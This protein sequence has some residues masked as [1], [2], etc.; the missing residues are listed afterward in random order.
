MDIQ[1]NQSL[2]D[3]WF[4]NPFHMEDL[5]VFD[6]AMLQAIITHQRFGV[7]LQ[8]LARSCRHTPETIVQQIVRRL[9]PVQREHLWSEL[10]HECTLQEGEQAQQTL[11]DALFWELIYWKMPERYEELTEGED[12]HPDLFPSLMPRLRGQTVVD[13]GAGWGRASLA[14]VE[15]QAAH[16]TAVEPSPGLLRLLRHNI[17]QRNIQDTLTPC[18]GRFEELPLANASVDY[19]LSCSAFTALNEQGG[20]VGLGEMKR[21]TKPG[22]QILILW[23]RTCDHAWFHEHGFHYVSLTGASHMQ[24]RFRSLSVALRCADLFYGNKPEVKAY[25]QTTQKPLLPFTVIGLNPPSD[26]FWLQR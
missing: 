21:V 19:A 10:R 16:V 6:E 4:H 5:L 13:V 17:A 12:I 25:L 24:I 20:E 26:Y 18:S 15:A 14:C 1:H 2:S 8:L 11:L 7:T 3:Q 9:S 22:G 23:P